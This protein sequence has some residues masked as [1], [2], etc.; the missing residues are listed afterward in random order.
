[1]RRGACE[2]QKSQKG[3]KASKSSGEKK[4]DWQKQGLP[5]RP[6]DREKVNPNGRSFFSGGMLRPEQLLSS[7]SQGLA[8]FDLQDLQL[9]G[10]SQKEK[11]SYVDKMS[12]LGT[13][14]G[15]SNVTRSFL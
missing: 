2:L 3:A 8:T 12:N 7:G 11:Q 13:R 14:F 10:M 15:T 6:F 1:M 4:E 9:P 5:W